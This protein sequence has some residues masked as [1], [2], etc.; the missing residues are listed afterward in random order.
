MTLAT[1]LAKSLN[2]VAAQLAME[3]GPD[4]VIEAAHRLGIELTL[5]SNASIALG[6][7]EVTP[8]ELTSAYAPF[9]NG[10]Y[11]ADIHVVQPHHHRRRRGALRERRDRRAARDQPRDRRQHEPD[12]A[13]D[14]DDR[15]RPKA[16]LRRPAAG[17]TGTTRTRATPGS[18]ATP[19]I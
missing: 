9:A 1:A 5:Q 11:K 3:V 16:A 4:A 13:A 19:A 14:V 12:D 8:L 2:T 10:G 6:T 7:S 17:K 15:Y 18:S